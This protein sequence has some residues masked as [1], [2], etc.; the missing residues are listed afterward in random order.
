VLKLKQIESII[1]PNKNVCLYMAEDAQWIGDGCA[2]YPIYGMPHLTEDNILT[3]WDVPE[4]KREKWQFR[5]LGTVSLAMFND[6][7]EGEQL[8]ERGLSAILVAGGLAEPLRTEQGVLFIYRRYLKP[9][10]DLENGYDL[11]ARYDPMTRQPIIAVKEGY[12]LVGIISPV[13]VVNDK[14]ISELEELLGMCKL[15]KENRYGTL[16]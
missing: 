4:E 13:A 11:Y 9:F 3:M 12:S 16:S 14:F 2:M 5:H 1:K 10:D 8:L 6:A 15:A 7:V